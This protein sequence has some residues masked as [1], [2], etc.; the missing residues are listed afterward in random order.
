MTLPADSLVYI[1]GVTMTFAGIV[2]AQV[3]NVLACRTTKQSIFKTSLAA[4]K[5]ILLGIVSQLSI[6]SLLVYVPFLQKLFGTT[7]LGVTDWAFLAL[8]AHSSGY[9]RRN[10]KILR[11]KI[12]QNSLR[13][14][15]LSTNYTP[16]FIE[17][18]WV[19]AGGSVCG[20]V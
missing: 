6:L 7:A 16:L 1:K 20:S 19:S 17:S 11:P 4:N 10:P 5:W 14:D 3:G 2:V 13:T 8:L 12:I 9:C 15:A 18:A